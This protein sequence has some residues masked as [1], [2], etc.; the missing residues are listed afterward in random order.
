[1]LDRR[2]QNATRAQEVMID[3]PPRIGE[4]WIRQR[5]CSAAMTCLL[6]R[7]ISTRPRLLLPAHR[8]RHGRGL[9]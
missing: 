7:D 2:R 6:C 9:S 3:A 8:C 1:M 4:C 5:D